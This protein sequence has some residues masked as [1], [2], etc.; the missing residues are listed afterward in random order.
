MVELRSLHEK[1]KGLLLEENKKLSAD[2][3]RSV[4]LSSRL[5]AD[6]RHLE[7]EYTE[8][9]VS[10]PYNLQLSFLAWKSE[11]MDMSKK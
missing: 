4:E 9:Q 10:Q 6:R 8:L 7:E 1:E 2:L 11:I 3:E 5:Q